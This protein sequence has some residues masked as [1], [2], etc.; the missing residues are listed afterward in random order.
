MCASGGAQVA[1]HLPEVSLRQVLLFQ[2]KYVKADEDCSGLI[3]A[4]EL[5]DL[6]TKV[7]A[8]NAALPS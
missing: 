2:D 1:S 6:L 4:K 7:R 5:A 8:V 3:D